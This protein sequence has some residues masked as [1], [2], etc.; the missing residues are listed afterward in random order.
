MADTAYGIGLLKQGVARFEV[1]HR[2]GR[3]YR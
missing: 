1:E 2:G 3:Q